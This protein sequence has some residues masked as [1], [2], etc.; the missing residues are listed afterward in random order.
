[1]PLPMHHYDPEEPSHSLVACGGR[2]IGGPERQGVLST[3]CV[4]IVP[5]ELIFRKKYP[6]LALILLTAL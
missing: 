4:I 2:C 1:M 3:G 5:S 6:R